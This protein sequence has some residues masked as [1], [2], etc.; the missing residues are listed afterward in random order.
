LQTEAEKKKRPGSARK[1]KK[2][3]SVVWVSGGEEGEMGGQVCLVEMKFK[4][5]RKRG[6]K[7]AEEEETQENH[8]SPTTAKKEG[9]RQTHACQTQKENS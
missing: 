7:K 8:H 3:A 6:G 5:K 4:R 1:R 9:K 2:T